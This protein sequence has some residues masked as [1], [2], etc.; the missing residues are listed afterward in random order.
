MVTCYNSKKTPYIHEENSMS[1]SMSFASRTVGLFSWMFIGSIS[2]FYTWNHSSILGG[3]PQVWLKLGTVSR[4]KKV[5][6]YEILKRLKWQNLRVSQNKNY[7]GKDQKC[8]FKP[9]ILKKFT[10]Q[11]QK[12]HT[13]KHIQHTTHLR[14]AEFTD[15][16]ARESGN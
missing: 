11:S 12:P 5:C 6:I 3:G 2:F 16:L 13:E 15:A 14:I 8:E 10:W 7:G 4:E 1:Y 9:L